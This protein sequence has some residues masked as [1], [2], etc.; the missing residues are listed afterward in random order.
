GRCEK[1]RIE[2][3]RSSTAAT[4]LQLQQYLRNAVGCH[5]PVSRYEEHGRLYFYNLDTGETTWDPPPQSREGATSGPPPAATNRSGALTVRS[6]S[7]VILS[8]GGKIQFGRSCSA[9]ASRSEAPKHPTVVHKGGRLGTTDELD[10]GGGRTLKT[11]TTGGGVVRSTL[12]QASTLPARNVESKSPGAEREGCTSSRQAPVQKDGDETK[13]VLGSPQRSVGCPEEST[14]LPKWSGLKKPTRQRAKRVEEPPTSKPAPSSQGNHLVASSLQQAEHW[15]ATNEPES[16]LGRPYRR[17]GPDQT[18]PKPD[19]SLGTRE[20]SG[21]F[22]TPTHVEDAS[23]KEGVPMHEPPAATTA[24]LRGQAAAVREAMESR[25]KE[26]EE[27]TGRPEITR[28]G[29]NKQRSV[30][31][32]FLFQ[33]N[34][35]ASRRRRHDERE[36]HENKLVTG[37][38]ETC[39]RSAV[40]VKRMRRGGGNDAHLPTSQR[41]HSN[42]VEQRRRRDTQQARVETAI[43]RRANPNISTRSKSL[44]RERGDVARRLYEQAILSREGAHYREQLSRQPPRGHTFRPEIDQRSAL[45]AQRRRDRWASVGL[46]KRGRGG[47]TAVQEFLLAEGTLYDRR[48]QERQSIQEELALRRPNPTVNRHSRRLLCAAGNTGRSP[49]TQSEETRSRASEAVDAEQYEFSPRLEGLG[50]SQKMLESRYGRD[51]IPSM[52][53]RAK[54]REVEILERRR[55]QSVEQEKENRSF[56]ARR[57]SRRSSASESPE[58]GQDEPRSAKSFS[59]KSWSAARLSPSCRRESGG[60]QDIGRPPKP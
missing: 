31:D 54:D 33:R 55:S 28:R 19:F 10:D 49:G 27:M 44:P 36:T 5:L 3:Y 1:T 58:H 14:P 38:P 25:R 59:R 22:A 52:Q 13:R 17:R 42:A 20:I 26:A 56:V 2:F 32:L 12:D 11:G 39:R 9:V 6:R 50:T 15:L 30:D 60:G 53:Q 48:R 16:E 57:A 35:E 23:Q 47:G 40:L 18:P 7:S 43:R 21:R 8:K 4:L 24:R 46:D 45:L 34:A 29:R 41:L 37:R 51:A